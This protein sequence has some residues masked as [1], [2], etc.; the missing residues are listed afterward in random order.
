MCCIMCPSIHTEMQTLSPEPKLNW[1]PK[2]NFANKQYQAII[3]FMA[4]TG[5]V[6]CL[7]LQHGMVSNNLAHLVLK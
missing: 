3:V 6:V 5:F 7:I 1:H 2:L 4:S